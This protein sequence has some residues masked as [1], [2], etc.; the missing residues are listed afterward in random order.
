MSI[1]TTRYIDYSCTA[2]IK[3]YR[4]LILLSLSGSFVFPSFT[5]S[6]VKKK[7]LYEIRII[8]DPVM[9][10]G[11][12]ANFNCETRT[13]SLS[14]SNDDAQV[15]VRCNPGET[16]TSCGWSVNPGGE[17]DEGYDGS[18]Q[19]D[20]NGEQTYELVRSG[21]ARNK[22]RTRILAEELYYALEGK[23]SSESIKSRANSFDGR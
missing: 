11:V 8:N 5:I 3:A 23:V 17:N 19:T 1:K 16:M 10:Q 12:S 9:Y 6:A 22:I 20:T 15:S 21:S 7:Y 18:W 2:P 14:G 4:L 13:S